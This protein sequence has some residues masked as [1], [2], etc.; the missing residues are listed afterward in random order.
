M[1]AGGGAELLHKPPRR[2]WGVQPEAENWGWLEKAAVT[3]LPGSLGWDW[4]R[5]RVELDPEIKPAKMF[6][7][8]PMKQTLNQLPG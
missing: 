1:T 8:L 2:G 3:P 6:N 4:A 5:P 7:K